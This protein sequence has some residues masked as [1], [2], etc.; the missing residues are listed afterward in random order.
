MCYEIYLQTSRNVIGEFNWD[1]NIQGAILGSFFWGYCLTNVLGGRLA[2]KF[3]G[4][5]VYGTGVMLTG[6]LTL[7]SPIAARSSTKAF[8]AFRVLEGMTEVSMYAISV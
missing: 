3:G 1:E 6:V 5:I 7:L 2:E 4:K 8:V